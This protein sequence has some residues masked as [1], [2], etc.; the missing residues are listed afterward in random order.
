MKQVVLINQNWIS[1][2]LQRGWIGVLFI[3]QKMGKGTFL[4][5]KK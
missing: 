1:L 3:L 2:V 5:K 4:V